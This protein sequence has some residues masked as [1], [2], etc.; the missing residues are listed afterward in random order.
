MN[1]RKLQIAVLGSAGPE[2]YIEEKPNPKAYILAE[3]VGTLIGQLGA[4]LI[5]GGKGGIMEAACRGAKQV[6]GIT[7]G[8]VSGIQRGVSNNFVDVEIVSGRIDN[9]EETQIIAMSD[10][11]IILGGGAGTLQEIATAYRNFKPMVVVKGLDGWGEKLAGSYLDY[12]NKVKLESA[13]TPKEAMEL[14]QNLL[15]QKE[16]YV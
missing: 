1:N 9:G 4:V 10:G 16:L 5:T 6:G 15:S 2:E 12:R 7:V 3:E 13:N 14:L 8:V 11:C